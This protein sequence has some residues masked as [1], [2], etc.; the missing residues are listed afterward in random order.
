MSWRDRL[1]RLPGAGG[2]EAGP[3]RP[4]RVQL[5]AWR[6]AAGRMRWGITPAE[7]EAVTP[8]PALEGDER[9]EGYLGAVLCYGFAPPGGK[10]ADVV[11]SGK[12]AWLYARRR[13]ARIWQCDYAD[14]DKPQ[15]LR[16]RPGAPSRPRGFYWVKFHPGPEFKTWSV[17]RF[18]R[19]LQ[20][21]TGAGPEGFQLLC[22]T[23]P[24]LARLMERG[25]LNFMALA[26]YDLAPHGFNDFY[27]VPQLFC[28]KGTLGFGVGNLDGTY[29]LFGIPRIKF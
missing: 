25:R 14:F 29:P 9:R 8:P 16:L 5:R 22:V 13:R 20:G 17:R 11:E 6:R 2:G 18:R 15:N 19:R 26:D 27:E 1:A 12:Q 28:S 3:L 4:A 21:A 10:W 7:F 24:H 23:H